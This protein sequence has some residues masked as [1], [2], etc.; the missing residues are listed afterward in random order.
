[1]T[2]KDYYVGGCTAL[3]DALGDTISHI[4][5]I[6]KYIRQEDVPSN[7]VFIITTDG[8]E[9]ASHKFSSSDVKKMISAKKELGWEFLFL[10]ANIDAV[11]T[12]KVYGI[13]E[14]R[15]VNYN[16]DA[17]GTAMAFRTL[18]KAVSRVRK[19]E[20]I[21]AVWGAELEEDHK[22]RKSN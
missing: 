6:H 17:V 12:A 13:S 1:M 16:A 4:E 2:E 11:E 15:A 8:M 20:K 18:S 9:N 3:I 21:S 22:R 7:T 10:G 14:D 19:D 5:D